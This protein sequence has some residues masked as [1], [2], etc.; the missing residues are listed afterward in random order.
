MARKGMEGGARRPRQAAA[1]PERTNMSAES[2]TRA[3]AEQRL[4]RLVGTVES[5]EGIIKTHQVPAE[6]GN[7]TSRKMLNQAKSR[8]GQIKREQ[9][10]LT[11]SVADEDKAASSTKQP[12]AREP[13]AVPQPLRRRAI[14][15]DAITDGVETSNAQQ[16]PPA[17]VTEPL[18]R[19]RVTVSDAVVE[20]LEAAETKQPPLR[21]PV[22]RRLQVINEELDSLVRKGGNKAKERRATLQGQRDLLLREEE[23]NIDRYK[24]GTPEGAYYASISERTASL[25]TREQKASFLKKVAIWANQAKHEQ[26]LSDMEAIRFV[27]ANVEKELARKG[28]GSITDFNEK[29]GTNKVVGGALVTG[30]LV[31]AGVDTATLGAYISLVAQSV[32]HISAD[33]TTVGGMGFNAA[34]AG[35]AVGVLPL[36]ELLKRFQIYEKDARK[37]FYKVWED[38]DAGMLP[39]TK[40]KGGNRL[41]MIAAGAAALGASS[42]DTV[43][44][45]G[46]RI[47]T[48][49]ATT[50]PNMI[51][52]AAAFNLGEEG[53]EFIT[54]TRAALT[55][56]RSELMKV[57]RNEADR[58]T[59]R[60][61]VLVSEYQNQWVAFSDRSIQT[62]AGGGRSVTSGGSGVEGAG[63]NTGRKVGI[64]AGNRNYPG[65]RPTGGYDAGF[66]W[67]LAQRDN[68]TH[69]RV[70]ENGELV[71][72]RDASG[73]P[74]MRDGAVQY[75]RVPIE[76]ETRPDGS[77][78]SVPEW[79]ERRYEVF[80][81]KA[82]D[83]FDQA[84]RIIGEAA[85][86]EAT[87][88]DERGELEQ[89]ATYLANR[90]MPVNVKL[91]LMRAYIQ[92]T[93][94]FSRQ[95]QELQDTM[96]DIETLFNVEFTVPC[97]GMSESVIAALRQV[98]SGDSGMSIDEP[99]LD[100]NL[101]LLENL[102]APE[103]LDLASLLDPMEIKR[104]YFD[105]PDTRSKLIFTIVFGFVGFHGM[106]RYLKTQEYNRKQAKI[107]HP[108]FKNM[109]G[110]ES[111]KEGT[112][113]DISSEFSDRMNMMFDGEN[114]M[115]SGDEFKDL[116]PFQ[117][118]PWM[119]MDPE[120]LMFYMRLSGEHS[121]ELS[122]V[123]KT[124]PRTWG[125]LMAKR[126]LE[127]FHELIVPT[128][129]A[130]EIKAFSK[131]LD[132][133]A[134]RDELAL[135]TFGDIL[136]GFTQIMKLSDRI[137]DL[138]KEGKRGNSPEMQEAGTAFIN[139]YSE[140]VF[141]HLIAR[142]RYART[143]IAY[144]EKV[145]GDL[146]NKGSSSDVGVERLG[147]LP[148]LKLSFGDSK[149]KLKQG[150]IAKMELVRGSVYRTTVIDAIEAQLDIEQ[151]A[152]DQVAD[153]AQK[154]KEHQEDRIAKKTTVF[155]TRLIEL[156]KALDEE[157]E[158][159]AA[160]GDRLLREMSARGGL[161]TVLLEDLEADIR[162]RVLEGRSVKTVGQVWPVEDQYGSVNRAFEQARNAKPGAAFSLFRDDPRLT[163]YKWTT[164]FPLRGVG[165]PRLNGKSRIAEEYVIELAVTDAGT[166]AVVFKDELAINTVFAKDVP[167]GVAGEAV[168]TWF[169]E[170]RNEISLEAK[171]RSM[172]EDLSKMRQPVAL[173][174]P[175]NLSL[176]DAN[177]RLDSLF[178]GVMPEA[179]RQEELDG[180]Q[181]AVDKVYAQRNFTNLVTLGR[182]RTAKEKR[183]RKKMRTDQGTEYEALFDRL[184]VEEQRIND[185]A[186]PK[187]GE[188]MFEDDSMAV[189]RLTTFL[190]GPENR[191]LLSG[192][193]VTFEYIP[194]TTP[195]ARAI[196]LT[197]R[198]VF[199]GSSA[200]SKITTVSLDSILSILQD[201]SIGNANER[202]RAVYELFSQR[203]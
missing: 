131:T 32:L 1:G 44:D 51:S 94:G 154:F 31:V 24:A 6:K 30:G 101:E 78:E 46:A 148:D 116:N 105:N 199:R 9:A 139:T 95:T 189:Q 97:N 188:K 19:Q 202:R 10:E 85:D 192:L 112:E 150:E 173:P 100:M 79:I 159:V 118:M 71:P 83:R 133:Y 102:D 41:K 21:E 53:Q 178:N 123:D 152:L 48:L 167:P 81:G 160:I 60:L 104:L 29:T 187:K 174:P 110:K 2:F 127:G 38:M 61:P 89:L 92:S 179:R 164:S 186:K 126:Y 169:R 64:L 96:Q 183:E 157:T 182:A 12:A 68:F 88:E 193:K 86:N 50:G 87:P 161:E 145:Y 170:K 141:G 184:K 47:A 147:N 201:P 17:V 140:M 90:L 107:M 177:G 165:S 52:T 72:L 143:R 132:R 35:F 76:F 194:S 117:E 196:Q 200:G 65:L 58:Q 203:A 99:T 134:R 181:A 163:K 74:V 80:E 122:G 13:A 124:D 146:K 198:R 7:E 109:Y 103:G 55:Q 37:N 23:Y 59:G 149:Q 26:K 113:F 66:Q 45:Q 180:V 137:K 63:T 69:V 195:L 155:A 93:A 156:E 158:P 28:K 25:R 121:N 20:E 168:R 5:L 151:R 191:R 125:N 120:F 4:A 3:E 190:A 185:L 166:G 62:E 115:F 67:G 108:I 43:I 111:Y 136:P 34:C 84:A 8:L 98:G 162:D 73:E 138:Q 176:G 130:P 14:V 142:T 70:D 27:S 16:A 144:L 153:L 128:V 197:D 54:E 129:H 22:A 114:G 36:A 119:Q 57:W 18:R 175:I 172:T 11:R 39:E 82:Q 77:Q 91:D 40:P 135:Q 56:A 15:D 42:L 171:I 75:E 49:A 33:V 106:S